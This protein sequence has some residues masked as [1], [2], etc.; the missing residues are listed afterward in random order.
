M[1]A[2]RQSTT[3]CADN[4]QVVLTSNS[5]NIQPKSDEVAIKLSRNQALV[6]FDWLADMKDD[7]LEAATQQ[8]LWRLEGM[9]EES[10]VEVVDADYKEKVAAAKTA[11]LAD[12]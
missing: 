2:W 11:L 5:M 4:R 7:S 9:L 3:K 12:E 1:E 6:L 8:V 10:L